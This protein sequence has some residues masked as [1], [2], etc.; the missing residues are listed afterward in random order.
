MYAN[1]MPVIAAE[2]IDGLRRSAA[3]R[4][5]AREAAQTAARPRHTA[6]ASAAAPAPAPAP[7][8]PAR[9]QEACATC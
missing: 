1:F 2:Q 8:R 6:S 3:A 4:R 5:L 7:A 9:E